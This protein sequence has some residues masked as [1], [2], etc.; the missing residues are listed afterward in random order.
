MV[1]GFFEPG[2]KAGGPIR[3]VAQIIYSAAEDIDVTL[4]TSDRDLGDTQPYPH[5]SGKWVETNGVKIFYFNKRNVSQ[6]VTLAAYLRP[7][8]YDVLY[9]NSLWSPTYSLL[10]LLASKI[11]GI[12]AKTILVAPRGEM[13]DGALSIH[14]NKKRSAMIL[15]RRLLG[16]TKTQWHASTELEAAEITR[17]FPHAQIYVFPDQSDLLGKVL[18]PPDHRPRGPVRFVFIS[19]IARMKN[20][21]LALQAMRKMNTPAT[22]DIYGPVE[23]E[24]YWQLCQQEIER[25]PQQTQVHYCGTLTPNQIRDTFLRY[26]AFVFPTLGENFGHVIPESLSA[27]CPVICSDFTPWTALLNSGGGAVVSPLGAEALATTLSD[28]AQRDPVLLHKARLD[29]ATAYES[30][31]EAQSSLNVIDHICDQRPS[32][33]QGVLG[34]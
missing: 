22:L 27:S 7:S 31:Y 16:T 9:L 6:W 28:W 25:L 19:R 1:C 4:I 20:L 30:W 3:S 17:I 29:A 13:S 2:F 24:S 34:S 12:K 21:L 8:R 23:D 14:R 33:H 5:L 10:P 32:S 18:L 11:R 15:W 26:D